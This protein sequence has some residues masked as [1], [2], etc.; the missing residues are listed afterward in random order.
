MGV[1][2]KRRSLNFT[3]SNSFLQSQRV[4]NSSQGMGKDAVAV[5][6]LRSGEWG[7]GRVVVIKPSFFTTND[8][9]SDVRRLS[10]ADA[11]S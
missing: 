7:G 11:C 9:Y 1:G 2:W 4:P 3:V 5:T 10:A 6:L 8:G